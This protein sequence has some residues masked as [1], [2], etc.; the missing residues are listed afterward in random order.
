VEVFG[1]KKENG[2]IFQAFLKQKQNYPFYDCKEPLDF[3]YYFAQ[4][5]MLLGMIFG[6]RPFLGLFFGS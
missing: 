6:S 1:R 2:F 4:L 5:F 3:G